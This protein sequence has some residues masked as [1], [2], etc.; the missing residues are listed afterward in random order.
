MGA[1][2]LILIDF[3]FISIVFGK[4]RNKVVKMT[5]FSLYFLT[6]KDVKQKN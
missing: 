3:K 4:I 1:F 6:Q 5:I 2:T